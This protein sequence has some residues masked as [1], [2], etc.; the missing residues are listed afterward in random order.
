MQI[1][2]CN[3]VRWDHLRSR[4]RG[5]NDWDSDRDSDGDRDRFGGGGDH[6]RTGGRLREGIDHEPNGEPQ[7]GA[8]VCAVFATGRDR[9]LSRGPRGVDARKGR[10]SGRV[11]RLEP[12]VDGERRV[13]VKGVA[14]EPRRDG[15]AECLLAQAAIGVGTA[16]DREPR[17]GLLLGKRRHG[18]REDPEREKHEAVDGASHWGRWIRSPSREQRGALKGVMLSR[19]WRALRNPWA[20][21]EFALHGPPRP[22]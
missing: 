18:T 6:R 19:V 8:E 3:Y 11:D 22:R 7:R 2:W 20:A 10:A 13:L 14:S 21:Y 5:C 9:P 1:Y 4:L 15:R 17:H 16:H 12:H